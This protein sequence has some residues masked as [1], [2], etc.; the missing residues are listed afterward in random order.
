M[1]T[2]YFTFKWCMTLYSCALP[3]EVL[4]HIFD[5]FIIGGWPA[6]Y[7]IGISLLNNYMGPRMYEMESMMEI[8]QFLREDMRNKDLFSDKEIH[9]ILVGALQIN[10]EKEYI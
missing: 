8:S 2:E 5:Q 6:I 9:N 4:I 10:I 3:L 1:R 7:K